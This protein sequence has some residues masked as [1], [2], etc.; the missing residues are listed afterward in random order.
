MPRRASLIVF[1]GL[2]IALV[3]VTGISAGAEPNGGVPS[4]EAEIVSAQDRLME[5]RVNVSTAQASYDNA[6][7]EMNHLNGQITNATEDLEAAEERL[8]EAQKDLEERASQVY[9]SGN[10]A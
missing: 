5:I 1:L 2:V 7:F 6:L 3:F 4:R 9:R 8:A 10:V